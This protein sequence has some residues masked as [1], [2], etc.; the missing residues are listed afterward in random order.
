MPG[1][2]FPREIECLALALAAEDHF[3]ARCSYHGAG[4][5]E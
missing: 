2:N 1:P 5:K 3:E 4:Q